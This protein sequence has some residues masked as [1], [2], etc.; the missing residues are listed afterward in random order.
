MKQGTKASAL[1]Q[2]KGWGGK[3]GM[4]GAHDEGTHVHP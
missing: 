4:K 2:P 1:G 3:G